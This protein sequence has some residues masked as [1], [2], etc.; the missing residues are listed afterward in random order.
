M[1]F[2]TD[3]DFAGIIA[4]STFATLKGTGGANLAKAEELAKSELD[5]LRSKFDIT[6]ELAKSGATRHTV[7]VRMMLNITAYYL[8]NTVVDVEI[9]ERIATNFDNEKKFIEKLAAGKASST[10]AVLKDEVTG[11]DVTIVSWNSNRKRSH[12]LYPST[13]KANS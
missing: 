11:E 2:L 1:A 10:I 4:T 3:N 13:K 12:E 7:I 9:P 6:A 5:P 8:Y